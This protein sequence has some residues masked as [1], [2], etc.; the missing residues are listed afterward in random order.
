MVIYAEKG[1]G[2]RHSK[3]SPVSTVFYRL[4]PSINILKNFEHEKGEALVSACPGDVFKMKKGKVEVANPRACTTCRECLKLE[5]V[6]LEKIQ[7][8][9][10]CKN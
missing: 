7:D 10:L 3:W 2:K 1:I 4:M 5:G 8:H 6:E 9:F